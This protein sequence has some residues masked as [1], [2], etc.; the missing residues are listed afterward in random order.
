MTLHKIIFSN[1]FI[2]FDENI[3]KAYENNFEK[4][5]C[6]VTSSG[7]IFNSLFD[8]YLENPKNEYGIFLDC[9]SEIYTFNDFINNYLLLCQNFEIR[10]QIKNYN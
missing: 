9:P 2:P 5:E 4:E 8:Y 3:K 6:K 1:E 10:N 7:K